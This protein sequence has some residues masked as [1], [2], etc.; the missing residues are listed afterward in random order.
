MS[1]KAGSEAR[2]VS[3]PIIGER[4]GN[5]MYASRS[6]GSG[7]SRP[8]ARGSYSVS[9]WICESSMPYSRMAAERITW[10]SAFAAVSRAITLR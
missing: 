2:P 9:R 4:S 8:N 6:T 3:Q 10:P 5:M 1:M 7:M